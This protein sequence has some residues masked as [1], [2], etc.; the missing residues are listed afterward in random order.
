MA[1]TCTATGLTEGKHCSVCNEVLVAQEEVPA[2]GHTEVIDAAVAPTCTESGL[3]EGKHCS[4]CNEVLVAQEEVP[5]LGHTYSEEYK[6][7]ETGH[8]K[9][10]ECGHQTDKEAH[11]GGEA[12]ETEK[13][14]CSV[15][16][17]EYG[18]L[19]EWYESITEPIIDLFEVGCAG[20]VATS[21]L[22]LLTLCC[23]VLFL[24]KKRE[25]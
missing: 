14:K 18:E 22:G 17:H 3:T 13:A 6:S 2:L 8:W 11:S 7:D 1:P 23:A 19:K 21:I 16:G 25:E 12:T 5:A 15:C 9:E 10:C 4:V 24:R 20:S